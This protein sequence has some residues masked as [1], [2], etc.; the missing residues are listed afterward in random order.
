MLEKVKK[1]LY[2]FFI[3]FF[4]RLLLNSKLY[5]FWV[6]LG[7]MIVYGS[8]V[9]EDWLF[10]LLNFFFLLEFESLVLLLD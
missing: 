6:I 3:V 1:D 4:F 8:R 2:I 10:V 9:S 5:F 7:N